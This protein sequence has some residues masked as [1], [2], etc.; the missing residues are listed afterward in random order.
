MSKGRSSDAE[1]YAVTAM[2]IPFLEL[3]GSSDGYLLLGRNASRLVSTLE[4]ISVSSY[5]RP[6]RLEMTVEAIFFGKDT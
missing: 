5:S 1:F 6:S 4:L 2:R 3:I